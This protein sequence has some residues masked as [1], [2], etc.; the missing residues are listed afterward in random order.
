MLSGLDLEYRVG[1]LDAGSLSG[2]GSM[3]CSCSSRYLRL[4]SYY[5]G[6]I[7]RFDGRRSVDR[8]I[9]DFEARQSIG[10]LV[11]PM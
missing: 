4:E 10:L 7:V 1:V 9:A 2:R 3:A 11:N 6:V 8:L 5:S